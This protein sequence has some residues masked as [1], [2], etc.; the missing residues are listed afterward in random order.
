MT[1]GISP[2]ITIHAHQMCYFSNKCSHFLNVTF[3]RKHTNF[4]EGWYLANVNIFIK[5]VIQ[6]IVNIPNYI[7]PEKTNPHPTISNF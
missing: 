7:F 2:S 1:Y 6:S 3:Q 5:L 4:N